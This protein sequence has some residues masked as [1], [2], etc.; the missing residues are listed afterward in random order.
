MRKKKDNNLIQ[1]SYGEERKLYYTSIGRASVKL[2]LSVPSVKWAIEHHNVTCSNADEIVTIG[3][4]DGS[5][6]P[7]KYI[8]ND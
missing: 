8:N 5:D 2:G 1:I 4:V 7:Y 3:I 6:I